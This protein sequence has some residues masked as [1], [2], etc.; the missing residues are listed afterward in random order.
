MSKLSRA[1]LTVLTV[2]AGG[3]GGCAQLF[4]I[5]ETSQRPDAD[6]ATP[7]VSVQVERLSFGATML[8]T[9]QDVSTESASYWIDDA[10]DPSGLRRVPAAQAAADRFTAEIAEGTRAAA[11]ISFPSLPPFRRFYAFPSRALHVHFGAFETPGAAPAPAGGALSVQLTLPSGYASGESFQLYAV[12]PWAYHPFAPA[13]LPAVDEGATQIGPVT[14]PYTTAGFPSVVGARPLPKLTAQDQIVALRYIGNDLTAAAVIPRFENS[15]E[16]DTVIATLAAAPRAALDARIDPRAVAMR[17]TGTSP[18]G[19]ALSMAWYVHAAPGWKFASSN[20]P[21]LQAAGIL[22]TDSGTITAQFANPF[23]SLGWESI[24]TW[25]ANRSRTYTVPSQML[26]VTLYSGVAHLDDVQ[27]GTRIVLDQPAGLPVVV[28]VNRMALNSDGLDIELDPAKAIELG[29]VADR[30]TNLY[31]QWNIFELVPNGATPPTA[32]ETKI[33]YAALATETTVKI[34]P[35][36]LAKGKVYTIRAH[37]IQGGFPAFA[38]GDLTIRDVPF[39]IGFH[40]SGVFT[41]R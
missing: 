6:V 12:G 18:M 31:Y 2:L 22:P 17:L 16:T 9:P 23:T 1:M 29:V 38:S 32:L 36:V 40:D 14:I 24:M 25:A 20:G 33:V 15:G 34:P 37:C 10:S 27:A 8:T 13:E 28:S 26:P 39:A 21:V 3:L 7:L 11:E 30:T 5:D 19:T 4:G 41:V 35:G